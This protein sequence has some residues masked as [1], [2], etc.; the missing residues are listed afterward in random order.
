MDIGFA[1]DKPTDWCIEN[2]PL[3][4]TKRTWE[5]GREDFWNAALR[6][7]TGG[8]VVDA[9]NASI[10]NQPSAP[11]LFQDMIFRNGLYDVQQRCVIDDSDACDWEEGLDEMGMIVALAGMLYP[12]TKAGVV[13]TT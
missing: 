4:A 2:M 13:S 8:G 6:G 12:E 7:S 10:A 5:A 3:P 11:L 9:L 1:C